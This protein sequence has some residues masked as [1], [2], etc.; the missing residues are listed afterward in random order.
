[1]SNHESHLIKWDN[2]NI[3]DSIDFEDLLNQFV[4]WDS[5]LDDSP[6]DK[7]PDSI[8]NVLDF[9]FSPRKTICMDVVHD[10]FFD[11]LQVCFDS[12]RF[13]V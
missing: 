8:S 3:L 12:F 2:V 6:N 5:I 7:F 9:A 4:N 10:F 13:Y 1:M 11:A